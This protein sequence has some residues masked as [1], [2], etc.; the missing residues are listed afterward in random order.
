MIEDEESSWL[1]HR[2]SL[3][4]LVDEVCEKIRQH[5]EARV[6]SLVLTTTAEICQELQ[7]FIGTQRVETHLD[8]TETTIREGLLQDVWRLTED[9]GRIRAEMQAKLEAFE[10]TSEHLIFT[11]LY[12]AGMFKK[13]YQ[14]QRPDGSKT[15]IDLPHLEQLYYADISIDGPYDFKAYAEQAGLA[16]LQRSLEHFCLERFRHL[17]VDVDAVRTLYERYP[18]VPSRMQVIEQFV[19]N[20]TVWLQPSRRAQVEQ[21]IRANYDD[22]V[23]IGLHQPAGVVHDYYKQLEDTVL[24]LAQAAGFRSSVNKPVDVGQDA[25]YFYSELAG[26]PLVYIDNIEDYKKVY[27]ELAYQGRELHIDSREEQFPDIVIQEGG[28]IVQT[29]RVNRVLF[30]GSILRVV[31]LN[32]E[33]GQTMQYAYIERS[34]AQPVRRPLGSLYSAIKTLHGDQELLRRIENEVSG[35][36]RALRPDIRRRFLTTLMYH[37]ADGS[38]EGTRRGPYPPAYILVGGKMIERLSPEYRAINEVINEEIAILAG[39]LDRVEGEVRSQALQEYATLDQFSEE[40]LVGS[41]P[42]RILRTSTFERPASGY[43]ARAQ[44][45]SR[46]TA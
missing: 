1:V 16:N 20:G 22:D 34:G 17:E 38:Q 29:I 18:D 3:R 36:R 6:R 5:F 4:I 13:Y 46:S 21:N 10:D 31:E 2:W 43:G 8:G 42:H 41:K 39:E 7:Q 33:P 28:E 44:D 24:N 23:Q 15:E 12:Q 9:L 27:Q 11:N 25:I 37:V 19:R 40:R 30:V 14:Q 26:I 32:G 35:R 45:D